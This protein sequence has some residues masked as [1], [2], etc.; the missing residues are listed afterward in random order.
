VNDTFLEMSETRENAIRNLL[1]FFSLAFIISWS[2]WFIPVFYN[3]SFP[4]RF[5]FYAGG[6]IGPAVGAYLTTY[7]TEKGEGVKKLWKRV[8][9]FKFDKKWLIPTIF[10]IPLA[11]IILILITG[12]TIGRFISEILVLNPSYL[13][14][15]FF[16]FYI[17]AA[18]EEVGWRGYALDLFQSKTNALFSS[19]ILGLIW[20]LWHLPLLIYYWWWP[21]QYISLYL[22]FVVLLSIIFT[23]LYN[24]TWGNIF[25]A[26]LFHTIINL[27]LQYLFPILADSRSNGYFYLNSLLIIVDLILIAIYKPKHLSRKKRISKNQ[28]PNKI[29]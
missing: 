14:L 15:W 16:L 11:F 3:F 26:T 4:I 5:A 10:G 6:V 12:I 2:I 24:N 29:N 7:L 18:F 19:L 25:I 20:G 8:W 21:I 28:K 22:I 13:I 17:A 23:F 9:S 1:I 27:S